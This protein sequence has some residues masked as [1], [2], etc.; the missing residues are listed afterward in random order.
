[1]NVYGWENC[2]MKKKWATNNISPRS[3]DNPPAAW[4]VGDV[5]RDGKAEI[6]QA[7][8]KGEIFRVQKNGPSFIYDDLE[9]K[10]YGWDGSKMVVKGIG[11]ILT[12]VSSFSNA[13]SWLVADVDKDGKSELIQPWK[14]G[15]K[16][17]MNVYGWDGIKMGLKWRSDNMGTAPSALSWLVGDVDAD[18]KAEIIQPWVTEA[19]A[20]L[21]SG[22]GMNA[23]GWDGSK[24]AVKWSSN[25]TVYQGSVQANAWLVGDVDGDGKA[26][27][28]QRIK[29]EGAA[30]GKMGWKHYGLY[31][32]RMA[33]KPG[34]VTQW[35]FAVDS[36]LSWLAGDIN[37]DGKA[38]IIQPWTHALLE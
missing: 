4:L 34:T 16:L 7:Q 15:D 13:L 19:T 31:G 23:Y 18:G 21:A 37:G 26:E 33:L 9:M 35:G 29:G 20:S 5:D 6:I 8:K 32:T 17:A 3:A 24:M 11:K 36:A 25:G 1:M 10:V 30:N 12:P 38:D 22:L 14:N 2:Q 27:I 28:I